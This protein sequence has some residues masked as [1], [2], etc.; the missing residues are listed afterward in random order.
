MAQLKRLTGGNCQVQFVQ[1]YPY[2]PMI[3]DKQIHY[4]AHHSD[5]VRLQVLQ[6]YGGIYMDWDGPLYKSY[7]RIDR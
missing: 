6:L 2:T 4:A 3:G 5:L 7:M 1:L